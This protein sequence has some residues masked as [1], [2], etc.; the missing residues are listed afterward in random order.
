MREAQIG[1]KLVERDAESLRD[2]VQGFAGNRAD[3]SEI[4]E[5]RCCIGQALQCLG[6][7]IG[8]VDLLL[9]STLLA[10]VIRLQRVVLILDRL[11]LLGLYIGKLFLQGL[12]VRSIERL[13]KL[14]RLRF[15][16]SQRGHA[17]LCG[18]LQSESNIC[19]IRARLARSNR[20][21]VKLIDGGNLRGIDAGDCLL[22]RGRR[23]AKLIQAVAKLRN[24]I[25]VTGLCL[26]L[27]RRGF[28]KLVVICLFRRRS[29]REI[30]AG[31]LPLYQ[32][33]R[34]ERRQRSL[35]GFAEIGHRDTGI[36]AERAQRLR[37]LLFQVGD[38]LPR[39]FVGAIECLCKCLHKRLQV[40]HTARC[41]RRRVGE[42]HQI[43]AGLADV[44]AGQRQRVFKCLRF[45][46][47]TLIGLNQRFIAGRKLLNQLR[48][49]R[50]VGIIA[51]Q[52][53]L[54]VDVRLRCEQELRRRTK[55]VCI[56]AILLGDFR[57]G[58][59]RADIYLR[60]DVF[61]LHTFYELV[62]CFVVC[63]A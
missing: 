55:L 22:K 29:L 32:L 20:R 3:L 16:S 36:E 6:L 46:L 12:N 49:F 5:Q 4:R 33:L 15:K 45:G 31:L 26:R 8:L 48:R 52:R 53:L 61:R 24:D 41:R 60:N 62:D 23:I 50:E 43:C 19:R 11:R 51:K 14:H 28:G 10:G 58:P 63:L 59:A 17:L 40:L 7:R 44:R 30:H 13:R 34:R 25:V 18:V 42:L 9:Q 47:Q 57:C 39:Q 56:A 54:L 1:G 27:G 37:Y 38:V 21:C 2:F 35:V